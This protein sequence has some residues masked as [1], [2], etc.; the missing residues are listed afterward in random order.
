VSGKFQSVETAHAGPKQN[1]NTLDDVGDRD[2]RLLAPV[3]H[4]R[5]D[6]VGELEDLFGVGDQAAENR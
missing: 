6:G 1:G 3:H 5:D 2:T 4:A